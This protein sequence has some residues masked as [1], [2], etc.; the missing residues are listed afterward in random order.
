LGFSRGLGDDQVAA[1]RRKRPG[2]S[3]I[4]AGRSP[5]LG[6]EEPEAGI[7]RAQVVDRDEASVR[8]GPEAR[9]LE[10]ASVRLI[11]VERKQ[12]RDR[13]RLQIETEDRR[14]RL[15]GWGLRR[16]EFEPAYA[17]SVWRVREGRI[18]VQR[19]ELARRTGVEVD[20]SPDGRVAARG[21]DQTPV[22]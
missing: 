16:E 19:V 13:P 2:D 18:T 7:L 21:Q 11:E 17:R 3:P 8:R 20:P 6:V 1:I 10:D 14:S 5:P 4:K 22:G 9:E 15:H 12:R